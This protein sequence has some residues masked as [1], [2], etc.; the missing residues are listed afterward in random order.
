MIPL[1]RIL[2]ALGSWLVAYLVAVLVGVP[3]SGGL[4]VVAFAYYTCNLLGECVVGAFKA[5]EQPAP[6][7]TVKEGE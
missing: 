2:L 3:W 1:V 4:I 5:N 7:R 6:S